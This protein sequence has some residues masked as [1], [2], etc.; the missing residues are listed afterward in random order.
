MRLMRLMGL[1]TLIA[2][3]SC[4][5]GSS[6]DPVPPTP[7]PIDEQVAI[8]FSGTQSE[9]EMVNNGASRTYRTNGAYETNEVYGTNGTNETYGPHRTYSPTRATPLHDAG[10]DAFTVWGYKNMAFAA[11]IY[12]GDG[13]TQ[14]LVFPGFTVNWLSSAVGTTTT[15]TNGWE[16]V[17]QGPDQTVKYWDWGALAYRFFAVTDWAG[18]PPGTYESYKT[19]GA[20]E[21]YGTYK[22]Y[23]ISM[24]ADA[25]NTG[26]MTGT[27]FFSHL[28]FSTGNLAT[29]PDKQ[30]GKPVTLEFVKPYARVRFIFMYSHPREGITLEDK[31][32]K[33]TDGS[34]KIVRKGTF[35]AVY[36]LTGTE[37]SEWYSITPN[38]DPDA[39]VN[40]ALTA[41][42]VDFDPEDDT[43][44]YP[45]LSS[46]EMTPEG[47]YMVMPNPTQGSYTLSVKVNNESKT[48]VVPEEYMKWL[49][50]YSYTYVFKIL[51]EGGVEIGWVNKAVTSW[52]DMEADWTV[53]NW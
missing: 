15:N 51:D 52:T 45:T 42:T 28:W 23:K 5:S 32:F 38:D 17:G 11:D 3:M 49:P 44:D 6:F 25:S 10:G 30:F 53:Y 18:D 35:T 40:K 41:F 19:Y 48:C 39:A 21:T 27:P 20:N 46:G 8:T 16:Y 7:E 47:W 4:S 33:P 50:G 29:Y 2:L 22:A 9:E 24:L 37:T 1:M 36:P 14:Q 13:T 34:K 43:L 26:A 31:S 12:D